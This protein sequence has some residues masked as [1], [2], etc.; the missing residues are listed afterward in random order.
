[1]NWVVE[2]DDVDQR[3]KIDDEELMKMLIVLKR[4]MK[5]ISAMKGEIGPGP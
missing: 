1:M 3:A 2:E 4:A 5:E